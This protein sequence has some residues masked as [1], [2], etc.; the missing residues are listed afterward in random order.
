MHAAQR[1]AVTAAREA[2]GIRERRVC[3]IIAADRSVMRDH[4]DAAM[5]QRSE[6]G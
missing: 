2:H 4:I 6:R 3:S 5:R 1:A